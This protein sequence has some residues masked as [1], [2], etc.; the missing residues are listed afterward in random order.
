[1]S[2]VEITVKGLVQGVGYRPYVANLLRREQVNATV[3]NTGGIVKIEAKLSLQAAEG[4]VRRLYD[5]YPEGAKISDI[6][7]KKIA[8]KDISGV[9]IIESDYDTEENVSFLPADLPPCK[10][11]ERELRDRAGRR[12]RYPFISCRVCGPRYSIINRTPYDRVNTTM[13]VY[14][15]CDKCKK[16]Y[17]DIS[18]IRY[19]AQTISCPDCGMKLILNH[20]NRFLYREEAYCE[21]VALIK[22]GFVIAIKDTGGYHFVCDASSEK[23]VTDLRRLKKREKKPFAL[24]V[25]DAAALRKLAYVNESEEE[26]LL[27]SVRPIVL[28]RA[29]ENN[30]NIS[31]KVFADSPYVGAMLPSSGL[32]MMLNDEFDYLVST[33][34]NYQGSPIIT[35]DEDIICFDVPVLYHEREIVTPVD[36]SIMRVVDGTVQVLRRG[37]GLVPQPIEID[38]S[39]PSMLALGADLKGSFGYSSGNKI[40]ISQYFGD[41]INPLNKAK[42]KMAV[43][44]FGNMLN[45]KYDR[46]VCDRHI[47]YASSKY[48]EELSKQ[49]I[50]VYH[51]RAH[52]YSVLAE[53]KHPDS[54]AAFSFDG[55]GYG[56]NGGVYGG[57]AYFYSYGKLTHAGGLMPVK[58]TGG[59]K[60]SV[61]P[62]LPLCAYL[63]GQGNDDEINKAIDEVIRIASSHRQRPVDKAACNIVWAAIK[64]NIN[65]V[66]NSSMGRLFD[67]VSLLLGADFY[68]EYEGQCPISLEYMAV[69][70]LNSHYGYEEITD[71]L[72]DDVSEG[73]CLEIISQDSRP[74]GDT[75]GLI[76][77]IIGLMNKGVEKGK[78]A[79]LFHVA[80]AEYVVNMSGLCFKQAGEEPGTVVLSGGCFANRLLLELCINKL[81]KAGMR[82]LYNK[83]VPSGD[84]GIAAGQLYLAAELYEKNK[85]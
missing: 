59:D 25:K 7:V 75:P 49:T 67:A 1:M 54:L 12:Y 4:L 38:K 5:F 46:V 82:V 13:S 58:M 74:V 21:A 51:H 20:K 35:S 55:T 22:S 79:V 73:L 56:E 63:A 62:F 27:S 24:V 41:L 29:K 32:F 39:I 42:Y 48:G 71:L 10:N 72:P 3:R 6:S 70:Y 45:L 34:A 83:A 60:A 26:L 9:S 37:R 15:P 66:E 68:N 85:E 31:K 14:E 36:D 81:K 19:F 44:R 40:Y 50:K 43:N 28:L 64:N 57:E 11:C 52:V 76:R 47:L 8:D 30:V 61:D 18:D 69:N 17:S 80:I 2:C 53:N 33:S 16:E 23:A 77:N 78:L 65:T 84:D